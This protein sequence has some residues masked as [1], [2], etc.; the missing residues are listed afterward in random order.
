[1]KGKH[2]DITAAIMCSQHAE[3]NCRLE[4]MTEQN[5]SFPFHFVSEN[6]CPEDLA[7]IT[8]NITVK[9]IKFGCTIL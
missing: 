2:T 3:R 9:Q 4:V 5:L 7:H 1:M 8:S 6:I